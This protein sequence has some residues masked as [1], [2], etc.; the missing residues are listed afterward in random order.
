LRGSI[1]ARVDESVGGLNGL[2]GLSSRAAA[3]QQSAQAAAVEHRAV[4]AEGR[5]EMGSGRF[6]D[7]TRDREREAD[8]GRV[9]KGILKKGKPVE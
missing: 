4:A 5:G 1:N 9:R 8:V 6:G 7:G 2:S 3:A